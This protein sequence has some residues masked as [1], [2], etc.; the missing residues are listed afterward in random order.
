MLRILFVSTSTTLGGAEK[1]LFSL[2]TRIDPKQFE[3]AGVVSLK[4]L[5]A[6]GQ[7][8]ADL[9]YKTK[10][11]GIR[12]FPCPGDAQALERIIKEERPDIV[13]ALM[14]QAIQLCRWVKRRSG[15]SFKLISSPRVGYRTRPSWTLW[16]DRLLKSADDLLIT[17]SDASRDFLIQ[18]QGYAPGKVLTIHNGAEWASSGDRDE[19]RR[20]LGLSPSDIL[21]GSVG[22]LDD[23]KGQ[24]FLIEALPRL[25]N[26]RCVII[27]EGPLRPRLQAQI[28]RLHLQNRVQLLGERD[29]SAWMAAFDIFV[30]PSLWEGLPNALMEAMGAGLP[31]VASSVDG[32]PELIT[33]GRE[34]LLVPPRDPAALALALSTL[35]D[36]Q[37]LRR[38]L[39]AA[40][41]DRVH[42]SFTLTAMIRSYESGIL[43][44]RG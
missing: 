24:G 44:L 16:V 35:I 43:Y 4:P 18:S 26:T 25:K 39:G 9:G 29:A 31:C 41:Q 27:G 13:I 23:Q 20:E 21:L 11:L 37:G 2:A 1:T 7:K 40:A 6:Y 30:L 15:L 34:G 19:K 36:D 42:A 33:P 38:R 3:V 12:R 5:G 8:L 32:V 28:D 22:R 14:Y 17:E 10:S